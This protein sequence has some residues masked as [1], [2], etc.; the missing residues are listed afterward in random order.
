MKCAIHQ[1]QFLP[2]LGYL[3]KINSSDVF[4]F[5]DD[6]QFKKNEY[7][8]RNR[9]RVGDEPRWLTVPV[10]FN[11]GDTIRET[12]LAGRDFWGEKA[13]KTLELNYA[14]APFY[15]RYVSGL[16]DIVRRDWPNLAELNE[17]T[18]RWLMDCF[19]IRKEALVSSK[20]PEFPPDP[21]GRL[22]A[23]CRHL[24]ADAYISGAGGRSYLDV[25]RFD[26]A[27]IK[28]EFQEFLHPVYPQCYI[29]QREFIPFLSAIDGLFNCGGG[30]EARKKLN[31]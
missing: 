20:M 2:W 25:A 26:K 24:G 19:D 27:G 15:R 13:L 31:I 23:V 21:T 3:N 9:V 7:Q 10:S 8:N 4:V 30:E 18:V 29:R 16:A 14:K 1:P 5:L 6:V 22:I 17:A 11:F 28:L 12:K